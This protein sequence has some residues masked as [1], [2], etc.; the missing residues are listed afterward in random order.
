M[1]KNQIILIAVIVLGFGLFAAGLLKGKGKGGKKVDIDTKPKDGSKKNDSTTISDGQ[2][3]VRALNI[4]D[5][6]DRSGTLEDKIFEN[7]DGLNGA[8]LQK[9]FQQFGTPKYF[10]SEGSLILGDDL[11]LFQW[12]ENE[13]S[14]SDLKKAKSI[15]KKSNL[16]WT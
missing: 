7:L 16:G 3:K 10:I 6:M 4:Y 11:N 15:F 14:G 9:V 12:L 8:S 5:A 13:L 2:A 1:A